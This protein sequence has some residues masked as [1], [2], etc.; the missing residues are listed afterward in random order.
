[1]A[2]KWVQEF[3]DL[4][5]LGNENAESWRARKVLARAVLKLA[6]HQP[7][8]RIRLYQG[9]G[10][11]L[12]GRVPDFTVGC[13]SGRNTLAVIEIGRLGTER[14]DEL[15]A[16]GHNVVTVRRGLASFSTEKLTKRCRRCP[17]RP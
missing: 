4:R 6:E 14:L 3:A 8:C 5:R 1:M 16:A 11:E 17:Y 15:E 2:A 9:R 7:E 12:T 13:D 10:C